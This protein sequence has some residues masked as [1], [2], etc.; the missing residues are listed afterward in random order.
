[1]DPG[2]SV[3]VSAASIY[4][5]GLKVTQLKLAGIPMDVRDSIDALGFAALPISGEHAE[6]AARFPLVH[7]DPWDRIIAA[8]AICGDKSKQAREQSRA[9]L[10]FY[11]VR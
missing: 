8:Q 10:D 3:H 5:I 7:R 2:N 9:C 6:H 11:A 4:E 1:M